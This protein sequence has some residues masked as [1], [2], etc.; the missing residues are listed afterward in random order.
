MIFPQTKVRL[1]A[2]QLPHSSFQ[3]F[4]EALV[5]SPLIS[6]KCGIAV[7]KVHFSDH[8]WMQPVGWFHGFILLEFTEQILTCF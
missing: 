5:L 2:V 1:S 7:L 3:S 8:P 6:A 4:L